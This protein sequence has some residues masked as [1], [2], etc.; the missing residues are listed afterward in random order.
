MKKRIMAMLLTIAMAITLLPITALA[1]VSGTQFAGGDGTAQNPYQ[2]A[3]AEQLNA[4]RDELSAH[5]MLVSDIDLSG[6]T[7]IPIGTTNAPFSGSFD[8]SGHTISHLSSGYFNSENYA[9]LF[10]YCDTGYICNVH[11]KESA[12]VLTLS[13]R[14]IN[15]GGIVGSLGRDG[16]VEGCTYDGSIQIT[17]TGS[18]G[19]S[20]GG[21]VGWSQ[22]EITSCT[23]NSNIVVDGVDGYD[24]AVGG[25]V[26]TSYADIEDCKNNGN[27]SSEDYAG[28]IIGIYNSRNR[29]YPTVS[30]CSNNGEISAKY[31]GGITAKASGTTI[32]KC[33]NSGRILSNG[34]ASRAA[35]IV[36][37]TT[38]TQIRLCENTADVYSNADTSYNAFAA[39]IVANAIGTTEISQCRN[40]G[41]ISASTKHT[42][43]WYDTTP[44]ASASGGGIVSTTSDSTEINDCYNTGKIM[45]S[46]SDAGYGG[47]YSS[48]GY[49]YSGGIAGRDSG[50]ITNCYNMGDIYTYDADYCYEGTIAGSTDESIEIKNCYFINNPNV[51]A[52]GDSK[53]TLLSVSGCTDSQLR[54]Q[55]TYVNFDFSSVWYF[56][57]TSGYPYPQLRGLADD[58]QIPDVPP[59]PGD[60][61]ILALSPANGATNVGYD[62]SNPPVFKITFDREI[63]SSADQEFVAD[64]DLTLEDT[65]AIYRKSDDTL[66]YK[67]GA[68]SRLRFTLTSDKKTL[69]I[70]PLNNHA[71]L[72]ANT[73]YYVTMGE[74]FIK[75]A[76]GAV[77]LKIEKGAWNFTTAKQLAGPS[78]IT[79]DFMYDSAIT[80]KTEKYRYSYNEDWFFE[81]GYQHALAQMSIRLAMTAA[82]TTPEYVKDLYDQL[83]F[84]YTDASIK[85]PTPTTDTIGYAI[86]SK[87]ILDEN[88]ETVTIIAVAVRGA[89]YE[90][91]WADN[92]NVGTTSEHAGFSRAGDKVASAVQEYIKANSIQ[93]NIKIWITGFSRAAATSNIA[94]QRFNIWAKSGRIPGLSTDDIFAYCFECPRTVRTNDPSYAA[95][96]YDNIF[97]I[98]NYID[99]V[100]KVAPE[101]WKYDRYGITYYVPSA[102]QTIHFS[103]DYI[104]LLQ[105]YASILGQAGIVDVGGEAIKNTAYTKGQGAFFKKATDKLASFFDDP[106]TYT[107][108][109]Q[110][111]I[112][113]I[114][115]KMNGGS[116]ELGTVINTLVEGVPAFAVL[117]PI[118]TAKLIANIG[119]LSRAHYPELC[120]A[121]MDALNGKNDYVDAR[122][123]QLIMN[124]PVD[125]S[126]F[127]SQGTLVAQILNNQ[128]VEI[129]DSTIAAYIDED[130]QKVIILPTDDEFS[131]D[132]KATDNGTVTYTAIEYNA[133]SGATE[134]VISYYEVSVAENDALVG[135]FE[136]LDRIP[137][138]SY[139]LY[140]NDSTDSL[141][142]SVTQTGDAVQN[143]TI[144][145][146]ASGN[147]AI[148]GGGYYGNGEF[149]KV[150]ATANS[151]EEFLGWY[152]GN[153]LTSSDVEYRFLVKGNVDII[154]KFTTNAA[155]D[156]PTKPGTSTT[157]N[158][159][160]GSSNSSPT[161]SI[162]I[163]SRVTGGT[164]KAV[165]TSASEGQRVTLTVTPDSGYELN[166][167][168]VTDG[169]GNELKLTAKDDRT[170]TFTMPNSKVDVEVDFV[171][172]QTTPNFTD[173]QSGAYYADA[174]A[175]AVEKGITAGTS[176]TTFSPNAPCTRAQIVT[177]LWRAAGS[178][179]ATASCPFTDI[180]VDSYY[181]DAV[182]WAV[183]QS[184]TTGTSATTFSPNAT[185]TRAQAVTFLYRYEKS[186]AV[187][188]SN[189]FTDVVADAYYSNAVQWAVEKN[190]TAGTSATTFSPNDDCTRA[191]IVT[192]LYRDMA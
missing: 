123:R 176:A 126:V 25:I 38:D 42:G 67:P 119:N 78:Q 18:Y 84:T 188:G 141:T 135:L 53:A 13:D 28:G 50:V 146:S 94:A 62:A 96:T 15:A 144:T 81:T 160:G 21:I 12:I 128:V 105:S 73:E 31:A 4:V 59:V 113:N 157:P 39:G 173:V 177:F 61:S 148:T 101:A 97:N 112:M 152:I 65:F 137:S 33:A 147:G 58:S 64:V 55:S 71:L 102:E 120:L 162:T 83:G 19:S 189:A 167:L 52:T 60:G 111:T 168:I 17:I 29:V 89:G 77:G 182:L 145:V 91:E 166:K 117:H 121:W 27:V 192:F 163:P 80:K 142:P 103:D 87:Q 69:V 76:D 178:P 191:Q 143:Y 88:G 127:D 149:A 132:I 158:Y 85:Y 110:D 6:D 68:D 138:A 165:P 86:G 130:D 190:V 153:T 169:K 159:G 82:A 44:A 57:S 66:V 56:D 30:S 23:N 136:N 79:G 124:C 180:P 5:Y 133:D 131:I 164:V 122:T 106:T 41:E 36:A 104:N 100:P 134:K 98:V 72:S 174:V 172:Q 179:K 107:I 90:Q 22:G 140:I 20:V 95:N 35:G 92:F 47:Y 10:G 7:W 1:A 70:T 74:G 125:I 3:T 37:Y 170:Y 46:A 48:K 129:E 49:A 26:G 54:Q 151:G 75:F 24:D 118:V 115:K 63:A 93:S 161:Y 184:I 114:L 150:T 40:S 32:D 51:S 108:G 45:A 11:I 186:P 34:S 171:R 154:A 139:P 109:Y 175:W 2:V 155:P 156:N 8:G 9:G 43:S 185:C 116:Y 16:R 187:N 99:L 14:G 181:Y 183:E